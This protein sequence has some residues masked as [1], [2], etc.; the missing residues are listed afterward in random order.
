MLDWKTVVLRMALAALAGGVIGWNREKVNQAAGFR[1]YM[2]VT[3]AAALTSMI[4]I[5]I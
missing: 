5:W 1:T 3:A 4:G 2:I